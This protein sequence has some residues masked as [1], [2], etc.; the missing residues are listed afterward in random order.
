MRRGVA[1]RVQ[2]GRGPGGVVRGFALSTTCL[3]NPGLTSPNRLG[4]GLL[5]FVC[6]FSGDGNET[7]TTN[8]TGGDGSGDGGGGGG[9]DDHDD[10]R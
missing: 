6:V 1:K 10:E 2:C 8:T 5:C 7:T 9:G 3:F 4:R